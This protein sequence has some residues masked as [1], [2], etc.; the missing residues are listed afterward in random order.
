MITTKDNKRRGRPP[1]RNFPFD[2]RVRLSEE[3]R[4][5]LVILTTQNNTSLSEIVRQALE[6]KFA[7]HLQI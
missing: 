2:V 1:G 5:R 7:L 4:H 6:L 3:L